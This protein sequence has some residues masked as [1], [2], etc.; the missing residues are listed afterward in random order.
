MNSF[1]IDKI[2]LFILELYFLDT[3]IHNLKIISKK[4]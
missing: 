3:Q 2:L 1:D 4:T